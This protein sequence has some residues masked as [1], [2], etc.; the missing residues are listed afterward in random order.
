MASPSAPPTRCAVIS[1]AAQRARPA[2]RTLFR[3]RGTA[4][5]YSVA[6]GTPYEAGMIFWQIVATVVAGAHPAAVTVERL[7]RQRRPDAVYIDCLQNI[8]GKTLA[9]AYSARESVRRGVDAA[10][11]DGSPRGNRGWVAA[12]RLHAA[13][14]LRTAR[15]GRRF[16]GGT[17]DGRA[18]TPRRSA[19]LRAVASRVVRWPSARS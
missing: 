12:L 2:R 18:G 17:T 8:Y 4:H 13:L 1:L 10:Y 6:S 11:M 16:L 7:V 3:L 15:A 14:D 5:L 9:C 19:R